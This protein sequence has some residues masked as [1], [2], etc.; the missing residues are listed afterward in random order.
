MFRGQPSP[1]VEHYRRAHDIERSGASALRLYRATATFNPP[2]A[3]RF[4]SEW[5]KSSPGDVQVRRA[6]ADSHAR[7]GDFAAARPLYE[8]IVRIA[9]ADAEAMNNLANVLIELKEPG[10]LP[11]AEKALALKPNAAHI[12]GTTGWAAVKAG[13]TDRGIQ[14]LRDARLRDPGNPDTRYFLAVALPPSGCPPIRGVRTQLRT[15]IAG[16]LTPGG[17]PRGSPAIA[18]DL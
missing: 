8:A 10:A 4:A 16:T 11:V 2:G 17:T 6:L 12:M 15:R 13:Q 5:L 7:Q 1:A 14:L 9:P 18:S 3:A